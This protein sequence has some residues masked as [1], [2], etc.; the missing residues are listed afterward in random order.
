M[1]NI[2]YNSFEFSVELIREIK[3][4]QENNVVSSAELDRSPVLVSA[5]IFVRK[6]EIDSLLGYRRHQNF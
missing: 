4:I 3:A 6:R 5:K 1:F 2:I